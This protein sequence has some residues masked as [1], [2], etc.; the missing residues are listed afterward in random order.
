MIPGELSIQLHQDS[1]I[2]H[3][4]R[5]LDENL[6]GGE[7]DS[8]QKREI[9]LRGMSICKANTLGQEPMILHRLLGNPDLQAGGREPPIIK[10]DMHVAQYVDQAFMTVVM[11]VYNSAGALAASI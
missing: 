1:Q 6:C 10:L 5:D 7:Y 3:I 9:G 4:R 2:R 11:S 8:D